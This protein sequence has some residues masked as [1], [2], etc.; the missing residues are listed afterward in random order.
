[1]SDFV[2]NALIVVVGVGI[3]LAV[4]LPS[5]M[6]LRKRTLGRIRRRELTHDGA[7]YSVKLRKREGAWRPGENGLAYGPA[8][9]TYTREDRPEGVLYHLA[10]VSKDGSVAHFTGPIAPS[11]VEGSEAQARYRKFKRWA[12][13]LVLVPLVLRLGCLAIGILVASV[14]TNI[15]GVPPWAW[16]LVAVPVYVTLYRALSRGLVAAV[17]AAAKRR[18]SSE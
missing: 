13:V 15:W 7:M 2:A 8:R 10:L 4:V 18:R 12:P 5:F 1:M 17:N 6:R 9:A 16:I 14:V 11:Q 3:G